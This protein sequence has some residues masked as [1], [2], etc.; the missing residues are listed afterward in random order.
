MGSRI[1]LVLLALSAVASPAQ[2]HSFQQLDLGGG[3]KLDYAVG[4]PRGYDAARTYPV[5][6][7]LPSG[8][9]DRE[10]V[11][12]GFARYGQAAQRS[13]FVV[14]SPVAPDGALFFEGGEAALPALF[15][16]LRVTY[17]IEGGRL[18]L[19][20]A[21]NGGC[22]AFR[23]ATAY[24]GQFRSLIAAPGYAPTDDDV[25]R[26]GSLRH[27]TVRM[28]VGAED[29]ER[30]SEGTQDTV[31]R[32][33]ELDVDAS[34]EVVPGEGDVAAGLDARIAEQLTTIRD[35]ARGGA[36][37]TR[38]LA[39][40]LDDYHDA[41]AK[42]DGERY[43]GHFAPEGVFL[44]TDATERWTVNEFRRYGGAA[45]ERDSAWIFVPQWRAVE[46][47][48]TGTVAWFHE[49]L[50]SDSFG[51][52]RGTGTARRIDGTWRLTLYDLTVPIPNDLLTGI[53]EQ[54]RDHADPRVAAPGAVTIYCV[55][56]AEKGEGRDPELTPV[57][58]A[59]AAA[60]QRALEDIELAA[61]YSSEFQRTRATVAPAAAAHGLTVT[62]IPARDVGG[63]ADRLRQHG[64]SSALVA[65]HS[66]TVPVLLRELGVD[67]PVGIDEADYD[68]LFIVSLRGDG[69]ATL[70]R[71]HYG[72]PDD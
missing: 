69:T 57:G 42:A 60:L 13:G 24:P 22:S 50:H 10:L 71:L 64:G 66:N 11:D 43:F 14:I 47:D 27:M 23:I 1:A 17:R 31:A 8:R 72:P 33:R 38:A 19:A 63:L 46:F 44:G 39:T 54:I 49:V 68:N 58:Q 18:H 25:A 3:A 65:G 12:A 4:L 26:L 45:F 70:L 37:P 30:W 35:Q 55:R 9:Q 5:L 52:C 67:E 48:P 41:A 28:F 32:L 7:A 59:R 36:G 16:H 53:V 56:H 20:G 6:L 62:E 51:E 15:R 61:V 2:E 29:A 21:G 34:A 40:V